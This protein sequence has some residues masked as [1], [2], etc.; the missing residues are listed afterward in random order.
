MTRRILAGAL[1]FWLTVSSGWAAAGAR[2]M[3]REA[4]IEKELEQNHPDLV[5]PLRTARIA[6]DK[7]DF[8]EAIR[9]LREITAKSPDYDVALRRLGASLVRVGKRPEGL[10]FCERAVTLNRS[11]ENLSTL[12][13][14]LVADQSANEH[15]ADYERALQLLQECRGKPLGNDLSDLALTAQVALALNNQGEFSAVNASL[16][17]DYPQEMVT[18]YFRAIE[19]ALG[20][21]WLRAEKEIR[22]AEKLGLSQEAVQKFLSSGVHSRALWSRAAL[23][24]A[25][26]LGLWSG[27]LALLFGLGFVLSKLTLRQAQPADA[28]AAVTSSEKLIRKLYRVV[29]NVAGVYYYISLP[30]VLVLVIGIVAVILYVF[31]MIGRIPIKLMLVLGIGAIFTIIAMIKSLFIRV[32]PSDPG[33]AL[34]RAEAEGLWQLAE[35][36]AESVGTRPIDEIRITPGTE[37]AV[38]ERGTWRQKL[39]NEAHRILILGTGVLS[40]FKQNEFRCV[41]AHEYGHFSHRDTAGGDIAMR[42]QNDML[43]FY[44]AMR[45]AG[46]ATFMNAA[47]HF[48][49]IYNFI[50][51][52]ISHGATRLQEILADRVA[53][54]IYGAPAFEGGL[55]HVIRR[56]L[57]FEATANEEIKQSIEAH[58]PLQNLYELPAPQGSKVA[59]ELE[60]ALNRETSED[61]THPSPR[62]RFRLVTRL[63]EPS[64]PPRPG[65]VWE[66]FNNPEAIR[67][68][69]VAL[70]EKRVA[71][72]RER[73]GGANA[74]DADAT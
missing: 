24:T 20:E 26:T 69:M 72:H 37:L 27:G 47:F 51:R 11:A 65:E 3:A 70:I 68:E 46:Q 22:R 43:K 18:H 30:V 4:Q 67:G 36:V 54:Q 7:E 38:Y 60:K 71:P 44:S 1:A 32:K 58:R 55:T 64:C 8:A 73:R 9:L 42:V 5:E 31:L 57:E 49:R 34:P 66:L 12:A 48:L 35:E 28:V 53:A 15:R 59:T 63:Q 10:A 29:L 6:Y 13:Y 52:R 40:G 14:C 17:R 56:S 62:D 19:A 39:R 45:E 74:A 25:V 61:D 21:H 2:D 41:L 23:A 33:R 16:A 50:F